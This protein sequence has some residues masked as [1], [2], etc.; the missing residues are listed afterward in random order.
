MDSHVMVQEVQAGTL[1][2]ITIDIM[3]IYIHK[4][5]LYSRTCFR[6]MYAIIE[7]HVANPVPQTMPSW[8]FRICVFGHCISLRMG[9]VKMTP[10][11]YLIGFDMV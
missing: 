8:G 11:H 3:Y 10:S 5:K 6:N 4:Y 2:D 1:L 9:C 7:T